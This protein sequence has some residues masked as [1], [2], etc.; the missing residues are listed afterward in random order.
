M[1]IDG[2]KMLKLILVKQDL[3]AWI[4]VI[5]LTIRTAGGFLLHSNEPSGSIMRAVSYLAE[6]IFSQGLYSME[7]VSS[8]QLCVS[9]RAVW[10]GWPAVRKLA[11]LLCLVQRSHPLL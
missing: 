6:S 11:L 7:S 3:G 8:K 4:G 2:R 10:S 9:S 1:G 5:W